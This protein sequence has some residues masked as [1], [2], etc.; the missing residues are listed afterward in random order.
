MIGYADPFGYG[1]AWDQWDTTAHG[2]GLSVMANEYDTLT[3]RLAYA[4]WGQRQL[5]DLL[6]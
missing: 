6:G 5:D 3:G 2:L 4:G 1:F